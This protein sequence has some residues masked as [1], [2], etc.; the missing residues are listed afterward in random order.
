VFFSTRSWSK[1]GESGYCGLT[2]FH[3]LTT[4]RQFFH[5]L[6][7]FRQFLKVESGQTMKNRPTTTFVFHKKSVLKIILS[8]FVGPFVLFRPAKSTY[9]C[10]V[11]NGRATIHFRQMLI[12]HSPPFGRAR[13]KLGNFRRTESRFLPNLASDLAKNAPIFRPKKRLNG[14]SKWV[15]LG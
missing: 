9:K 5:R 6:T 3:R 4:F 15:N 11:A 10:R 13:S 2:I 1:I 7:T 12:F 14:R 8:K